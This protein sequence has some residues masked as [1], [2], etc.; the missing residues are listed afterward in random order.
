MPINHVSVAAG[1]VYREIAQEL[2]NQCIVHFHEFRGLG[3]GIEN[4]SCCAILKITAPPAPGHSAYR[5]G[6]SQAHIL[7]NDAINVGGLFNRHHHAERQAHAAGNLAG[8]YHPHLFI[9]LPPCAGATGCEAWC[10]ATIPGIHVWYL[11]P[12]TAAMTLAHAGG[13]PTQIAA[14]NLALP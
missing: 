14:L 12:D 11:Y 4:A 7:D 9:E 2:V 13:T 3:V 6:S 10:A 8:G 5:F 1:T